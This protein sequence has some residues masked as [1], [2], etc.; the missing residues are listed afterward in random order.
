MRTA[1]GRKEGNADLT[2][3][4]GGNTMFPNLSQ[5]LQKDLRALAPS[6][7]AVKAVMY[8]ERKYAA[9]LG[10]QVLPCLNGFDEMWIDKKEYDEFGPGIVGRKC[11]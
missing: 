3:Q 9:C 5:R 8:P 10:G 6:S 4:A 11:A 7:M 2:V 1:R